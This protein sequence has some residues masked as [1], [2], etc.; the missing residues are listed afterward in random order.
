MMKHRTTQRDAIKQVIREKD[1]ALDA[2]EI[3]LAGCQMVPSLNQSTVF[4]NLK[5]LIENGWLRK[6]NHPDRGP[7]Y[8]RTDKEHHHHFY[9]RSCKKVYELPGCALNKHGLTPRGFVTEEHE[10][11]LSGVCATCQTYDGA[12]EHY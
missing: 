5:L 10:V 11:F 7:L 3:L 2:A 6:I 1:R 12:G 9:C 8:E 4:R